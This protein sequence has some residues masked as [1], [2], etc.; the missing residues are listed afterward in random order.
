[1]LGAAI[2]QW[3]ILGSTTWKIWV[4]RNKRPLNHI[5][6]NIKYAIMH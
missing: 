1:M 2:L 3:N 6:R 5:L 4:E